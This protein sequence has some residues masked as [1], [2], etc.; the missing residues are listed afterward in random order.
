VFASIAAILA[1]VG[2]YVALSTL[3]RQRTAKIG[4]RMAV[5]SIFSLVVGQ[6][7]RLSIAGVAL[8]L[9]AAIVLT[10]T[11]TSMLVGITATDPITYAGMAAFFF[12]IAAISSWAPAY[13]RRDSIQRRRC[14]TNERP[15]GAPRIL[16]QVYI[17]GMQLT[18]RYLGTA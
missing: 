11:M 15:A 10:R 3:V 8:G 7:M 12:A 9:A 4:V 14:A 18:R 16:P 5:A 1:G 17:I 2:L 13:R 6:G